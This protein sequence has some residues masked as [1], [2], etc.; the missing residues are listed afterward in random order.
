MLN[1]I[2]SL[3]ITVASCSMLLGTSSVVVAS[4]PDGVTPA[5]EGICDG[6]IGATPGLYGLCVAYCE[7]MDA[8]ED[9]SDPLAIT[10]LRMPAQKILTNY[11]RKQNDGDPDMPCVVYEPE[12]VCPAW[13]P[14]ELETVGTQGWN[15]WLND[16]SIGPV[17]TTQR[18]WFEDYEEQPGAGKVTFAYAANGVRDGTPFYWVSYRMTNSDTG[19]DYT[20]TFFVDEATHNVCKQDVIDNNP[21]R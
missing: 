11:E 13:T 6:L 7:A 10:A 17:G 9:L 12:V 16:W 8:P 15:F 2:R 19:V 21:V 3:L 1:F 18:V 4:T 5:N 14:E 20:N